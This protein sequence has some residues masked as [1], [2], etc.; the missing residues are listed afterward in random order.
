ME[1]TRQRLEHHRLA[2]G[3]DPALE[4]VHLERLALAPRHRQRVKKLKVRKLPDLDMPRI[5]GPTHIEG[6]HNQ[7]VR[8]GQKDNAVGP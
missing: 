1:A 5:T 8:R 4:G 2:V 7:A 6:G 3:Q